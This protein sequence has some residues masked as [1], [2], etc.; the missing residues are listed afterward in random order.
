MTTNHKIG[1][2]TSV[3]GPPRSIKVCQLDWLNWQAAARKLGLNRSEYIRAVMRKAS[4]R[5]LNKTYKS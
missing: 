5:V 3:G 4:A 1:R 2:P